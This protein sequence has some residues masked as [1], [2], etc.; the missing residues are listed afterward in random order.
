MNSLALIDDVALPALIE[1]A[2]ATLTN[3]KTSAEVLAARDM[4]S[5]AYDVAKRTARLVTIK[6]AHDD[7]IAAIYRSQAD[8]LVIEARAKCRL[9]D[10][11]DAAQE[12]GEVARQGENRFTEFHDHKLYLRDVVS[13]PRQMHEARELRDA[14]VAQP[15]VVRR[16]V[17]DAIAAGG[18]PT[19]A[20]LK[21]AVRKVVKRLKSKK[22]DAAPIETQHE[23]DL[24]V[25]LSLWEASCASA[26]AE[27]LTIINQKEEH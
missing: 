13:N 12:R 4:A 11:Y 20:K 21:R 25:L 2:A 17:D 15:G 7:V 24:R 19:K 3:A 6:N 26:R 16:T 27:F 18:E 9:A 23:R 1:R 5:F 8:A 14:E 22:P 10:E